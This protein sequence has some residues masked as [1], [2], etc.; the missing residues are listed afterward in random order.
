RNAV[1]LGLLAPRLVASAVAPPLPRRRLRRLCS[2]GHP[3]P[4]SVWRGRW[5]PAIVSDHKRG[6][7]PLL[8]TAGMSSHVA[9]SFFKSERD[10]GPRRSHGGKPTET[11]GNKISGIV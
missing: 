3:A 6:A 5:A 8:T 7:R 10:S 4:S 11:Y 2:I 1:T 9:I